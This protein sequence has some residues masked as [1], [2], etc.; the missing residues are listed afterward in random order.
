[1]L[2]EQG[3]ISRA[4]LETHLATRPENQ[5]VGS[6]L[7][8]MGAVPANVVARALAGMHG[9]FAATESHFADVEAVM[10]SFIPA[11][12]ARRLCVFPI[13]LLGEN[14][15][16][17]AVAFLNPCDEAARAEVA[18]VCKFPLVPAAAAE[19]VIRRAIAQH[20]P[21]DQDEDD[22]SD[23][24]TMPT[25]GTEVENPVEIADDTISD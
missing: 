10:L 3:A 7:I 9:V 18:R 14:P 4:E 25:I 6:H 12:M 16:R 2:V 24:F 1:M 11:E 8:A 5:R 22:E 20:Y 17:V 21:L 15:E 19:I 23:D 13:G